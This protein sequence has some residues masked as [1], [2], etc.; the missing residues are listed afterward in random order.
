[1]LGKI[2]LLHAVQWYFWT[3]QIDI[4]ESTNTSTFPPERIAVMYGWTRCPDHDGSENV[5]IHSFVVLY[6]PFVIH[7]VS[8]PSKTHTIPSVRQYHPT[9]RLTSEM[10]RTIKN[11]HDTTHPQQQYKCDLLFTTRT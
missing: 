9:N 2:R 6:I 3:N 1:M 5:I 7:A 10:R 11:A 4:Q 8:H